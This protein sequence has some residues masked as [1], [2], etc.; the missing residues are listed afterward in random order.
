[1]RGAALAAAALLLAG[2]GG[3]DKGG[4]KAAYQRAGD[5]ICASYKTAIA[6]LGQPQQVSEIGPFITSA[7]PILRRT[8]GQIEKLDPPSDLR[9]QYATFREA[10]RQAVDRAEATQKAAEA[11]DSA[12]VQRLLGEAARASARRKGLARAAGLQACANL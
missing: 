7:M 11:A 10:A 4:D 8:V 9:D 2:C 12:E 5:R 1:M 3:G 6:K